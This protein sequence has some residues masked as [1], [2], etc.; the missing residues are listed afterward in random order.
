MDAVSPEQGRGRAEAD[1]DLVIQLESPVPA[2][3]P[4][5]PAT[6]LFCSGTCFHRRDDVSELQL[7]VDGRPQA[8]IADSMPRPGLF[9]SLHPGLGLAAEASLQHDPTCAAD[10]E[11]RSYRSGFWAIVPIPQVR[12]VLLRCDREL[13]PRKRRA[14][15]LLL[16]SADSPLAFA[17]LALRPLRALIGRNETLGTETHLIRGILWLQLTRS[18]VRGRRRPGARDYDAEIPAFDLIG[19]GQT[20]LKRWLAGGSDRPS[21]RR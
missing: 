4:V 10:P 7:L 19:F 1:P 5:G 2:S 16:G 15:E 21:G 17:W 9:R 3:L 14:L 13:T 11:L 12:V 8:A 6:A 20:R 18:R